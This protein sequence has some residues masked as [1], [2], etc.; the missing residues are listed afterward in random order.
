MWRGRIKGTATA[1]LALGLTTVAGHELWIGMQMDKLG[2]VIYVTPE[3]MQKG[4]V[5]SVMTRKVPV[6]EF[7]ARYPAPGTP[8]DIPGAPEAERQ[9]HGTVTGPVNMV[10]FEIPDDGS[11]TYTFR[12][13]PVNG[14]AA[15]NVLERVLT[16]GGIA[17]SADGRDLNY[18]DF[19]IERGHEITGE[20]LNLSVVESANTAE[21]FEMDPN[22]CPSEGGVRVC[23]PDDE[24]LLKRAAYVARASGTEVSHPWER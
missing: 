2:V 19:G 6:A 5:V 13:V 8:P 1:V 9:W 15:A 4:A 17:Y 21:D 10:Y 12:S 18:V 3:V 14:T 7:E 24:A 23:V 22:T 11:Y 16:I 20:L